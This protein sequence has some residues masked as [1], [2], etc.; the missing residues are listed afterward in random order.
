[1]RYRVTDDSKLFGN[2]AIY[3]F[4]H[5]HVNN[6]LNLNVI[7]TYARRALAFGIAFLIE[8]QNRKH[9]RQICLKLLGKILK[10]L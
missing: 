8:K 10:R 9:I 6:D 1:M 5:G 7:S 4:S 3:H 2:K